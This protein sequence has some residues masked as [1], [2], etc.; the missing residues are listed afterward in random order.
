M[1]RESTGLLGKFWSGRLDFEFI[2]NR[3]RWY[4]ASGV[5]IAICIVALLARGLN[6]GI[7]F[8]GGAA[9]TAPAANT[10]T[11][12]EQVTE[13]IDSTGIVAS[14]EVT[15]QIVGDSVRAQTPS[16]TTEQTPVIRDAI[17]TALGISPDEVASSVIGASW[18]DQVTD[19]ALIALVIFLALVM[20]MIAIY[21]RDWKYSIAAIVA[22]LHDL[23]IT[24]GVYALV[25]FSVTPTTVT[26][27][28]TIL[29]YSIYDT[30]VVF[31][32]LRENTGRDTKKTY[33]ENANAAINQVLIRSL[34]TTLIGVL[35]VAALLFAGSVLLGSG[36]LADVGLALLVGM[37]AG[38]FSSVFIATPLVVDLKRREAEVARSD[39]KILRKRT[40]AE[41]KRAD[42]DAPAVHIDSTTA[43]GVPS[44]ASVLTVDRTEAEKLL[45]DEGRSTG[46]SGRPQPR[47]QTRSERKS[48]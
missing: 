9:F 21:F 24:I 39:S 15:A 34:N 43:D 29:G 44:A 3:R 17:A 47:K 7:E 10:A 27:V 4:I 41:R 2:A 25:G 19:R 37:L 18:G 33:A 1:A 12:A 45:K 35:P 42:A 14:N 16:L 5:L 46:A 38:A 22:L 36:P 6:L 26:A 11:A 23:V 40:D 31:D 30:V 48:R 8:T 13:A 28:L 20:V 32:K